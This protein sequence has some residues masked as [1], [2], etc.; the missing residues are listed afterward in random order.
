MRVL[1]PSIFLLLGAVA[2]S[3]V[4]FSDVTK[5]ADNFTEKLPSSFGEPKNWKEPIQPIPPV[6]K[7]NSQKVTLGQRLFHDKR[8]SRDGTVSCSSCH[9]LNAGGDDGRTVS[10]GIDGALGNINAPTVFN[11]GFNFVQFWDGRASTLED[12]IDGPINHPKEMGSN[13]PTIEKRLRAVPQYL[14]DFV[15]LYRDGITAH[16]IKDALASFERSLITPDSRFD[17]FLN[18]DRTALTKEEQAGYR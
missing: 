4:W 8:L 11:S 1:V 3:F 15:V 14:A 17:R 10:V 6:I 12:Q 13:W 7:L 16:N 5:L 2:I 18:G 9:D